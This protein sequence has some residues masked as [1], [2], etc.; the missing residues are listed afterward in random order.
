[1]IDNIIEKIES[2]IHCT[3]FSRLGRCFRTRKNYYFYDLGTGKV[4]Q[5]NK[6]TFDILN[7]MLNYNG[8]SHIDEI[9]YSES[10]KMSALEELYDVIIKENILQAPELTEFI[11]PQIS[12]LDEFL[13][14]KRKQITLELTEKCNMRCKY[15]IYHENQGGYRRFGNADMTFDI[16]KKAIDDLVINS[17]EET[18]HVT[19]YGGEPLLK[20]NLI[21]NC[22]DYCKNF[23]DKKISYAITTNC[24]LVTKEI[25]EYFSKLKNLHITASLDG[26]KDINDKY[27]VYING[28][29]TFKDAI[30]GLKLLVDMCRHE[31][32]ITFGINCVLPEHDISTLEKIDNFF[33]SLEWL[34][35]NVIFTSSFVSSGEREMDYMGV[36]S[37]I[38]KEIMENS[39]KIK[40]YFDPL[41]E[42]A[43]S[44]INKSEFA[45]R[46]IAKDNIIKDLA[47]IHKRHLFHH[48]MKFYYMNGCCVPGARR[49]YVTAKGE[50]L[51]CE[52]LGEAPSIG[53]VYSG[54]DI[55]KIKKHYV[56]DYC[57]E[58][59]KYC[60]DCWA[61]HLCGMCYMNCYDKNGI[62]ISY[63]HSHCIMNR[64]YI[65]KNLSLYH[66][67]LE[68]NPKIIEGLNDYVFT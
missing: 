20:F 64:I 25:A 59:L 51:I 55:E 5:V 18:I 36:D 35:E 26:P 34:P 31:N 68:N 42:W 37:E 8:F 23:K 53:D 33:S 24:T 12:E 28:K 22:I 40:G 2:V 50:Y 9:N 58:A 63:R 49:V 10:E 30:A 65:E 45:F 11:G 60:K 17:G 13:R 62:H 47:L 19:F 27:R 54:L 61:I 14:S 29:G 6:V 3:N 67:L 1:L 43:T 52:K 66:E 44:D 4:F 41:Y 39:K 7:N 56:N 32:S 21:K 48:P 16:A 46:N 57:N 15:C 38:E